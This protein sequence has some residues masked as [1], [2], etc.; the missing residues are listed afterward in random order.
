MTDD[1]ILNNGGTQKHINEYANKNGADL[2]EADTKKEEARIKH[3][4]LSYFDDP[5]RINTEPSTYNMGVCKLEYGYM[6]NVLT[7]YLRRPGLLI[8]TAGKT[9]DKVSDWMGCEIK[10][11]EVDLHTF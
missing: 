6:S 8:G 3:L 4:F 5:C 9:I 2:T 10:I 11:V 1:Q 7:V